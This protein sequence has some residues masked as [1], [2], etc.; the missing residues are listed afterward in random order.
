[1]LISPTSVL[2]HC[3][4]LFLTEAPHS[5]PAWELGL[6]HTELGYETY[7]GEEEWDILEE[8]DYCDRHDDYEI[9]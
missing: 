6:T 1:M 3:C 8:L 7:I 4:L 5:T 9:K 2:V